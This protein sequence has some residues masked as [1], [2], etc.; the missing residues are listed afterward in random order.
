MQKLPETQTAIIHDH[1]RL[2]FKHLPKRNSFE[3]KFNMVVMNMYPLEPTN[4]TIEAWT[5]DNIR[6]KRNAFHSS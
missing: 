3:H 1:L 4:M 5:Y 6:V 2:T